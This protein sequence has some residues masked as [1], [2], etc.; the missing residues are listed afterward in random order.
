MTADNTTPNQLKDSSSST[1]EAATEARSL[2]RIAFDEWWN[3][4]PI[5]YIEGECC[6][7]GCCEVC[8]PH[9]FSWSS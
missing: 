6:A 4:R 2:A 8:Q 5:P 7:S 1:P 9:R 3:E